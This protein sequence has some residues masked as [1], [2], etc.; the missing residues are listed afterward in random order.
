MAFSAH[1][2]FVVQR[3]VDVFGL[4]TEGSCCSL[5]VTALLSPGG[6]D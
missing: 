3:T 6:R 4:Q 1:I 5:L 2:R